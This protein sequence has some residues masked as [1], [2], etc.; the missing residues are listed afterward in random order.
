MD[1]LVV[2]K[3]VFFSY[4]NKV[5]EMTLKKIL[6]KGSH[7]KKSRVFANLNLSFQRSKRYALIGKNGVGKSTIAL[8]I[9]NKVFP[10]KGDVILKGSS[11]ALFSDSNNL[12][13]NIDIEDFIKFY[14]ENLSPLHRSSV[15]NIQVDEILDFCDLKKIK[16]NKIETLSKGMRQKLLLSIYT[17]NKIDLLILDESLSGVDD[18]FYLKFKN[19]LD[20]CLGSEGTLILIDHNK[21]T[22]EY[23][24]QD[25]I[26]IKSEDELELN[27]N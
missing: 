21:S 7:N 9:M 13:E 22:L 16:K 20:H 17:A 4:S 1:N 5:S 27:I 15:I 19:R 8:M 12:F 3:D 18:S 25:F 6:I 14:L 10:D 24:C 26:D 2:F 23:F 11:L